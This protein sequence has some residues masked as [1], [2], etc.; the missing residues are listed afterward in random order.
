[1]EDT[2]NKVGSEQD[3]EQ[4]VQEQESELDF[5][6]AMDILDLKYSAVETRW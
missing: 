4:D 6:L 5:E 2:E 1:M 3:K